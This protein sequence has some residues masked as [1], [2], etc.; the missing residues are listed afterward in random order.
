MKKILFKE[1]QRYDQWWFW[2]MMLAAFFAAAGPVWYG[3]IYQ[4]NTGQPW[5]DEPSSNGEL[6]LI[7]SLVTFLMAG[8]LLLFKTLR[9]QVEIG[10]DEVRFR[11]P[12][13]IRKW[14]SIA[15]EEIEKYEVGKYR[16]IK[17]YGGWGM[18]YSFIK[19]ERAITVTGRTGLKLFLKNGK[20][21]LLG[22]QRAHAI[23]YAME[24]MMKRDNIPDK[25]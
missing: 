17:S 18:R 5:G 7:A 25:Y 16:H 6:A 9:L 23:S 24:K 1:E 15:R 21:I 2:L 8:V 20:V 13:L 22:S 10:E 19:R 14:R 12:P 3:L 4:V 11:Y